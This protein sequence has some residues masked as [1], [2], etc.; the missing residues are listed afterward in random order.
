MAFERRDEARSR[1]FGG[2]AD[3]ES[4]PENKGGRKIK[5]RR[6]KD[7]LKNIKSDEKRRGEIYE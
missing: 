4:D 3:C 2:R 6:K 7:L 1:N 5:G